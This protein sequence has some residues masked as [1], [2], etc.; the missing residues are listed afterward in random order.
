MD[1]EA[2]MQDGFYIA[3]WRCVSSPFELRGKVYL[4]LF[5]WCVSLIDV[6]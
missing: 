1:T 5:L 2:V 4:T 6:S 3:W